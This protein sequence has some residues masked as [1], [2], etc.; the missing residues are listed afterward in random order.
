[1]KY[2]R[3]KSNLSLN[4][5]LKERKKYMNKIISRITIFAI[6]SGLLLITSCEKDNPLGYKMTATIDGSSFNSLVTLAYIQDN[7]MIIEGTSANGKII[8][9]TISGTNPGSYAL[10][11]T[12]PLA[13]FAAVYK[14]SATVTTEDTWA[15]V[16]GTVS[17]SS[18]DTNAKTI[19]G[20]FSIKMK[21]DLTNNTLEI[22]NGSFTGVKYT[23]N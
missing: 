9:L 2:A 7:K 20:T 13:Q 10:S 18:V 5:S 6:F 16:S 17:L 19:S 22:S 12:P 21:K 8:V 23:G 1:M 14:E 4:L 11:A 15:S 3:R